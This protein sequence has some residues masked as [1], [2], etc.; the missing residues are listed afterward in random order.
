MGNRAEHFFGD[1]KGRAEIAVAFGLKPFLQGVDVDD[2]TVGLYGFHQAEDAFSL[3]RGEEFFQLGYAQ[4]G[5]K[6]PIVA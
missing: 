1:V 5:V 4:I 6:G 3:P 2:E